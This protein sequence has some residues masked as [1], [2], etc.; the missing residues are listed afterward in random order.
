MIFASR[1]Y[2]S[3]VLSL[4]KNIKTTC[5]AIFTR[6][7]LCFENPWFAKFVAF[8]ETLRYSEHQESGLMCKCGVTSVTHIFSHGETAQ[9]PHASQ[10]P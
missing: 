7:R 6:V 10:R 5:F 9:K 1:G 3:S 2:F 4:S 8:P